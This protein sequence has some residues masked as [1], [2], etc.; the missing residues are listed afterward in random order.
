MLDG[1]RRVA[2]SY[3]LLPLPPHALPVQQRV[4]GNG[5]GIQ[6]DGRWPLICQMG[7][8]LLSGAQ[9]IVL[10]HC[11]IKKEVNSSVQQLQQQLL[12]VVSLSL[13][14]HLSMTRLT[15]MIVLRIIR[16]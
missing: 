7:C 13:L 2:W 9:V 14:H 16:H 10:Q 15:I 8:E 4:Q 1:A 6:G 3:V 11:P 5:V 12:S